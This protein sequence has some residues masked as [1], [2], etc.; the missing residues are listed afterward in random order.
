MLNSRLYPPRRPPLLAARSGARQTRRSGAQPQRNSAANSSPSSRWPA[1]F[2]GIAVGLAASWLAPKLLLVERQ[3]EPQLAPDTANTAP[4]QSDLLPSFNFPQLFK[5]NEVVVPESEIAAHSSDDA[6][7]DYYVQVG[8]FRDQADADTLRVKL[9][10]LNLDA[11]IEPVRG[12]SGLWHRV[13]VGP[14]ASSA[15]VEQARNKLHQHNIDT[16]VLK[17]PRR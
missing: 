2:A 8:S 16:L 15:A 10:L 7:A 12:D 17:R 14:L 9:L 5:E 3:L 13:V 11:A 6:Q 1:F 4:E